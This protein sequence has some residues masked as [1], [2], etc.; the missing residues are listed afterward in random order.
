MEILTV[1]ATE[2]QRQNYIKTLENNKRFLLGDEAISYGAIYAGCTFYAGYPITPASEIA[3]TM[4]SQLPKIGGNYIQMEDEIGSMGAIIGASWAGARSM[5]ATSGPGFSLMQENIGYAVMT[6]TPCV[7]VD[8][9]RSGP[10]TGQATKPAQGDFYQARWGTHGDHEIIALSPFSVEE[11][12][13]LTI[14]C[15]ELAEKYRTPVI[16]LTDGEIAHIREP[17]QFPLYNNLAIEPAEEAPSGSLIFGGNDVPPMAHIGNGQILH[18]TGSTHKENG[19][20]DVNTKEVHDKLVRRLYKKIDS[21]R[22]NLTFID[23]K[24]MDD[25]DVVVVCW[26]STAR[27]ALG[28]V[29]DLRNEGKRVGF[30]RMIGI[31]PFPGH[32]IESLSNKIKSFFVPEL[33]LGLM[34]REIERYTSIPVHRL[35]SIGGELPTIEELKK[36]IIQDCL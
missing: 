31:W 4:A 35:N 13:Y 10:S 8:V 28:A 12:F 1:K 6:E 27:I 20:R 30:L 26:G 15:F 14:K 11:A 29:E 5:T 22:Q 17:F 32:I 33:N 2:K 16:L 36:K 34:S 3:E 7:I 18:V 23:Q 25:A 19:I 24:W 9:Q 21:N